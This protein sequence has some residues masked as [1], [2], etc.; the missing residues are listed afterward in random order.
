MQQLRERVAKGDAGFLYPRSV[1]KALSQ[2][3]EMAAQLYHRAI[4]GSWP[5]GNSRQFLLYARTEQAPNASSR[6]TLLPDRDSLGM[7]RVCLDWKLADIDR[8]TLLLISATAKTEFARLGLGQVT[9]AD[10]ITEEVWPPRFAAGPHHMGTTRM[11]A[12]PCDGVVDPNAKVHGVDN[13]YV[14]GSSIFPTSG[15]ANP[16]LTLLAT[17]LRL[18]DRLRSLQ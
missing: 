9:E 11:S 4:S 14:A 5:V 2:S 12:S 6:I 13:L 8:R 10:W 7:Q 3:R 17:S 15:H 18:A 16:T 1:L